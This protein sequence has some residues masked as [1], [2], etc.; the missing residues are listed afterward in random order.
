MK[1]LGI[2]AG[3]RKEGHTAQLVE[4]VLSGAREAGHETEIFFLSD[5]EINP[6]GAD[7]G[8]YFY[9]E[10]DMARLYPHIESMGALVFGTPIYYDHVS[11]RAKLFIDR[12]HYYS[13]THGPEYRKRF[14]DGV[15]CVNVITYDWDKE[16]AYDQVLKWM[17]RR[18]EH[19]W[20]MTTAGNIKAHGTGRVIQK[21]SKELIEEAKN[22]GRSL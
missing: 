8:G 3:P 19:Y 9:P 14:P 12:L 18:M 15:K 21:H 2:V 13:K 16:D 11:S 7:E 22:I 17:N 6:I 20:N 1:I 5:L 4:A 10:D